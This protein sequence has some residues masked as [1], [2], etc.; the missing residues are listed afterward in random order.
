MGQTTTLS[1]FSNKSLGPC[2]SGHQ[3]LILYRK[4]P[5]LYPQD[6]QTIHTVN[7]SRCDHSSFRN[8]LSQSI[9]LEQAF[10]DHYKGRHLTL[11]KF[12]WELLRSPFW[13]TNRKQL[14]SPVTSV[15]HK[16]KHPRHKKGYLHCKRRDRPILL[17]RHKT[18]P[19]W[20]KSTNLL[21]RNLPNYFCSHPDECLRADFSFPPRPFQLQHAAYSS[22]RSWCGITKFPAEASGRRGFAGQVPSFRSDTHNLSTFF[23]L[24]LLI[25]KGKKKP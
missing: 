14:V 3:P 12:E 21:M 16:V 6:N 2:V 8:V 15:Q 25:N 17:H 24:Y 7:I 19:D 1:T 5:S 18:S 11:F 22:M 10:T 13:K 23:M 20:C 4:E 9:A